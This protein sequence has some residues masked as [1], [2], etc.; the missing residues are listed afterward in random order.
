MTDY[1]RTTDPN[2]PETQDTV[3]RKPMAPRDVRQIGDY[4][5]PMDYVVE[6]LPVYLT[7]DGQ[8]YIG[9]LEFAPSID[10][11]SKPIRWVAVPTTPSR[12]M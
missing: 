1:E 11:N 8:E 10:P 6:Y 5:A 12:E 2:N 7:P 3:Y 9:P 4:D